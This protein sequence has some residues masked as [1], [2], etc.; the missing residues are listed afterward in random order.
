MRRQGT[1]IKYPNFGA[2]VCVYR[3]VSAS[4]PFMRAAPLNWSGGFA[5]ASAAS[6]TPARM[7]DHQLAQRCLAGDARAWEE[8]VRRHGR[9][10]YNLCLRFTGNTAEAED[11]AQDAAVKIYRSLGSY[12]AAQGALQTWIAALTRNLLIDHYRRARN[13]RRTDSLDAA[14]G[15]EPHAAAAHQ[16]PETEL[17]RREIREAVERAL[18]RISPELREA[19]ILRDLQDF[20]YKE[21][22]QVLHVPE[23]TVKSR[24][25]RGRIELARLLRQRVARP[26]AAAQEAR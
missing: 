3:F 9:Q 8:L 19:V 13:N 14:S 21:I 22:A 15:P 25:N 2:E 12:N 11:L 26:G 20:D 1:G 10:I 18:T 6:L 23:G 7:E 4:I 16:Q 17:Y 24:I 5:A